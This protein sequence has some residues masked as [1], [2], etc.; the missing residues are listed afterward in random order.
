MDDIFPVM[1]C[2]AFVVAWYSSLTNM[3]IT[4]WSYCAPSLGA[5]LTPV[6]IAALSKA[7]S[8]PP[9]LLNSWREWSLLIGLWGISIAESKL[10]LFKNPLSSELQ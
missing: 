5:K 9:L 7:P 10:G 4:E 3:F 2:F 1:S 6:F 8:A